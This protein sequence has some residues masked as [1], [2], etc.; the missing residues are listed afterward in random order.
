[1]NPPTFEGPSLSDIAAE[2]R[3]IKIID[4][5]PES[6]RSGRERRHREALGRLR[7]FEVLRFFKPR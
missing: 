7:G 3:L 2:H 5:V 4:T 1:M 6:Q